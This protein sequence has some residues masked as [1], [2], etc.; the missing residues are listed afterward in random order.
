MQRHQAMTDCRL[1]L[2]IRT[3]RVLGK[4]R[5]VVVRVH[6]GPARPYYLRRLGPEK[7]VFIRV[8]STNRHADMTLVD[9]LRR[10][11]RKKAFDEHLL[12]E[13]D[14]EAI[15][16][17]AASE[18]FS[19]IQRLTRRD[20][21]TL[22]LATRYQGKLLPTA[23]G[24]LLFDKERSRHFPDAWIQAGRF[25]GADRRRILDTMEICSHLPIA[26]EEAITFV[27]RNTAREAVI[28]RVRRVERWTYPLPALREAVVN[29][30]VHA[31]YSQQGAPIRLSSFDDRLE[32]ESPWLLP[33]GLKIDD[34]RR[35]SPNSGIG[36]SAGS[37]TLWD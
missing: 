27:Q 26:V 23:G 12:T 18:S 16:F 22:R 37:F 8:G 35:V 33:F 1:T 15:D 17:R 19:G 21:E 24:A 28:E 6:P 20:L 10:Y 29:A 31:D 3:S 34:I 32:V 36:S 9:E 2:Q 25:L 5:I 14:L 4:H 7:G 11:T 13:L 30:V